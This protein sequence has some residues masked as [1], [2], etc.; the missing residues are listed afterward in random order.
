[1]IVSRVQAY[2]E[3]HF[4]EPC[5]L[6]RL[7]RAAGVTRQHLAA[8]FRKHL[9]TTPVRYLWDLRT[10]KAISL[11]QQTS[12]S[13]NEIAERCGYKSSYH[14]SREIKRVKGVAPRE[15]RRRT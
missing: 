15:L 9:S 14:L 12:L 7:A 8:V 11:V 3:I 4:G 5:D 1:M 2:A 13:L 6:A 10:R